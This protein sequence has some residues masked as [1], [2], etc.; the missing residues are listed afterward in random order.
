M[1]T[2]EFLQTLKE[3]AGDLGVDAF[4]RIVEILLVEYEL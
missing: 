1:A 4:G 2:G 3:V